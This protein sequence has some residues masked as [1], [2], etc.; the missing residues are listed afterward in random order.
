MHD[1]VYA[2]GEPGG[3]VVVAADMS[4]DRHSLLVRGGHESFYLGIAEARFR[5]PGRWAVLDDDLDGVRPSGDL[6]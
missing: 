2:A 3:D 1:P 4:I 6:R 5:K